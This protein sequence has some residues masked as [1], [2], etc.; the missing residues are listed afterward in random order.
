MNDLKF[1]KDYSGQTVDDLLR[2]AETHRID[3]LVL[4][5]ESALDKKATSKGFVNLSEPE[6]FILA[7][8]TLEREV[9]NGGYLQFFM[10]TSSEY[11]PII[12]KALKA[13]LCLNTAFTTQYAIN[14]FNK[15]NKPEDQQRLH[16]L[17]DAFDNLY[18]ESNECIE[19]ELFE[20]I[21]R[22]KEEI[23]FV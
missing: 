10:N 14:E 15:N 8:E 17:M 9:N 16:A 13:I 19:D 21:K 7:I 6:Q 22:H 12:V 23:N 11:V 5:F 20:Y 1:L 3:S 2:M 4:A 18:F